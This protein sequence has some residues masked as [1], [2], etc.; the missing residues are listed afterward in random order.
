MPSEA[1]KNCGKKVNDPLG[2]FRKPRKCPYCGK[3]FDQKT[4]TEFNM[5]NFVRK[6]D[7]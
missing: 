3:D 1:C 2:I 4:I 6:N 7:A 5:S